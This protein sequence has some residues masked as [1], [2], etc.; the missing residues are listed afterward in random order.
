M[1]QCI[2]SGGSLEF[3]GFVREHLEEIRRC[4][5]PDLERLLEE[6]CMLQ[7]ALKMRMLQTNRV[8]AE[9]LAAIS[10]P[11][12][13]IQDMFR[14]HHKD[15]GSRTRVCRCGRGRHR[16][17]GNAP[18][19]REGR[20][21]IQDARSSNPME[22]LLCKHPSNS[23]NIEMLFHIMFPRANGSLGYGGERGRG[24][25]GASIHGQTARQREARMSNR[26]SGSF[27]ERIGRVRPMRYGLEG[28]RTVGGGIVR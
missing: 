26:L 1:K 4:A 13:N 12:P 18:Y 10:E 24:R 14:R 21:H 20:K 5:T 27:P 28:W 17:R 11:A 22:Y 15:S 23:G 7:D 16:C 8:F 9:R 25:D 19:K 6:C 3:A 2:M